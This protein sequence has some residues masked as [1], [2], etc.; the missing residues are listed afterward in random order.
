MKDKRGVLRRTY[1]YFKESM[2]AICVGLVLL[3]LFQ[4]ISALIPQ[5]PQLIID[6]VLNP[7]MGVDPVYSENNAFT[8]LLNGYASDDYVGMLTLLIAVLLGLNVL[9]YIAH[10]VRW[11]VTHPATFKG[12]NRL[13]QYA[14]GKML[15]QS[16]L[17]L[18]DYTSG[19]LLN[20]TAYDAINIKELYQSQVPHLGDCIVSIIFSLIFLIGISPLLVIVPV[21]TGLITMLIAR[22]YHKLLKDKYE[23]IRQA[24]VA[25]NTT[26]QE[27]I[28][29][30]RVVRSFSTEKE[31]IERFEQKNV[32]F[33][34]AYVEMAKTTSKYSMIFTLLGEAVGL[35][36]MIVAIL[37]AFYGELSVGEFATYMSYCLQINGRII[38]IATFVGGIQ[39]GVIRANRY[40]EFADRDEPVSEVKDAKPVPEKPHI[41]FKGVSMRF[42]NNLALNNVDIDIPY[43]KKVGIMGETGSGKSVVMKLMCR[44]YDATDG[45]ILIDGEDLRNYKLEE[46][47]ERFSFVMQD[48]FLFSDTVAGNIAFYD[49]S[50]PREEV[51]RCARLAC[52]DRFIP[53]LSDGYETVVGEKGLGLSG[54]QKQRVSIARAL[55]KDAPVILLDDCTS[56]LDYATEKQIEKNLNEHYGD[57]TIITCSH[58][59][60]AV[61]NC[62]EILYFENGVIVERGT[63]RELMKMGGRYATVYAQQEN[64]QREEVAE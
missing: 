17:V 61:K 15:R 43:G 51:E 34:D 39:N 6:R 59:A 55:L 53:L 49:E 58:R 64:A 30:V 8:F 26:V 16:P 20:I 11:N 22:G 27:N 5:V 3:L 14:F 35:L 24:N 36:S 42:P 57:R 62:D 45:Q 19:D 48:V 41:T 32:G 4:F 29:G 1:P 7:V 10:Y 50:V 21:V 23:K 40:F 13:T 33:R 12:E 18:N 37:I 54:G 38:S 63:H 60:G 9:R 52:V 31:E 47:R 2:P 28:N 46:V 56:A 25:L 44:L